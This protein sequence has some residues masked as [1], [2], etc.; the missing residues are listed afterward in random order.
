MKYAIFYACMIDDDEAGVYVDFV[1]YGGTANSDEE[2]E[3]LMKSLAQDR[4]IQGTG[5]AVIPYKYKLEVPLS[6]IL[7]R[8]KKQFKKFSDEV[9]DMEDMQDRM[10]NKK[11]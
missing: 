10:K 4:G 1:Y 2:A 5:T 6:A 7:T 8:A 3:L 11:G 9:Y